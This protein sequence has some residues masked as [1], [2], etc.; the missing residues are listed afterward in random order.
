M[1]PLIVILAFLLPSLDN[2]TS[3]QSE[4]PNES[5]W[6]IIFEY[7][8]ALE[9]IE[10]AFESFQL[11]VG[12]NMIDTLMGGLA[13]LFDASVLFVASELITTVTSYIQARDS[14]KTSANYCLQIHGP[15][16]GPI[17]AWFPT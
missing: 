11:A 12:L 14:F 2:M 6:F 16:C 13:C 4:V 17:P 15:I 7:D 5:T 8:P 9:C 10:T 3:I 1:K